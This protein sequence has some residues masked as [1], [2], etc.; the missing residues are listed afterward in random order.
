MAIC[1]I[2]EN[3]EQTRE[4]TEEVIAYVRATGPIPPEGARLVLGG[5]AEPGWRMVSVWDS[6]EAFER[7]RTRTMAP[8]FERAGLSLDRTTRTAFRVH[9]LAAGDLTAVLQPA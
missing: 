6:E 1:V 4:Q 7:F 5:P 9:K 2:I 3:P 8:A